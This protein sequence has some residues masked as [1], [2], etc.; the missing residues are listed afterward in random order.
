MPG[1]DDTSCSLC[2]LRVAQ[3]AVIVERHSTVVC[4]GCALR[5]GRFWYQ[6]ILTAVVVGGLLVGVERVPMEMTLRLALTFT[7]PFLV[8]ASTAWAASRQLGMAHARAVQS[9]SPPAV[10]R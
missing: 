8:S 7:V 1:D 3:Y 6:P 10:T 4:G 9:Q 2:H 5:Q